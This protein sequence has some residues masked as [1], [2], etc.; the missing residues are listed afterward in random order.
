M[1]KKGVKGEVI[2]K[3]VIGQVF[4]DKVFGNRARKVMPKRVFS[5]PT[6]KTA[7]ATLAKALLGGPGVENSSKS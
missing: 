2:R 4:V 1:N 6:P 3:V 7:R 5:M